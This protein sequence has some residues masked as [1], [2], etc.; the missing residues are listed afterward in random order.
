MMDTK[1]ENID[2]EIIRKGN[3]A[4]R[5]LANKLLSRIT[6]YAERAKR[7]TEVI[8]L[9]PRI[10]LSWDVARILL[11]V[12]DGGLY[13]NTAQINTICGLQ[14]EMVAGSRTAYIGYN[15]AEDLML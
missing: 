6:Y 9:R 3:D 1:I 7:L 5:E 4:Y 13:R 8:P 11:L 10:Y 15:V 2:S 12:V 14:V